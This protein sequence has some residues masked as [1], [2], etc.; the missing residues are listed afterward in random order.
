MLPFLQG[1][2]ATILV[3]VPSA[4][5]AT[6]QRTDRTDTH[7]GRRYWLLDSRLCQAQLVGKAQHGMSGLAQPATQQGNQQS[8]DQSIESAAQYIAG[9][10]DP[11][12]NT[13]HTY[14]TCYHKGGDQEANEVTRFGGKS[15]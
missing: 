4:L 11:N 14:C 9:I 15:R 1:K 7:K 6:C 10:M 2:V 12:V 5:L 3:G 8:R 13:R